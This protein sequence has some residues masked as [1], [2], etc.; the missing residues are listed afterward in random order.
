MISSQA[1]FN[2]ENRREQQALEKEIK[3]LDTE[4]AANP[5]MIKHNKIAV[6]K[7]KLNK[8]YSD[9]VVK[10]YQYTK[11]LQFEFGDKPQKLLA[12]QLR[13]LEGE[14]II[15]RIKSRNGELL[16][17]P[18]DI[19]E[20]FLQYYKNLYSVKTAENRIGIEAF[21]KKCNLKG[22][23]LENIESLNAEI[24]VKEIEESIKSLKN[25]KTP[26]PDGIGSEFYKTFYD[27]IAPRLKTLYE[28]IYTQQKLPETLNESIITLIPK[29]DKD[30]D[31][32]GSYRAIALLNTDQKI[33]TKILAQRLS[34]VINKLIHPDQTGF[35]PKR[36][37][38]YNLRRLFNIIYSK[39]GINKDLVIIS[40]DAEKAFDQVEWS[41]LFSV[42]E[43]FKL[44]EKFISWVKLL[45]ANPTA[46]ILTNQMLST[47]FNLSRGCRQ[48]CPLSPLLFALAIEPLAQSVRLHPEIYGYETR[49]TENKISLYADDVLLYIT[50]PEISILNLL[51]LITEFGSFSG[52]SINWNKSELMP[53]MVNNLHILQQYPFKIAKEKIKYLGIH[54]TKRYDSLFKSNF[55]PLLNKLNKNILY[56][57][58]LPISML[59]RINAIKM[60]FLP[61]ILYLFQLIPIYLPKFFF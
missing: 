8:I 17:N 20:R 16:V 27:L 15:H 40:L 57:K 48:G 36:Y 22:L 9:Q 41:Y 23:D 46:R 59:G 42:M 35:I 51:N 50:K 3:Q 34:T 49:E 61:Q 21:K 45:Y 32:P 18:R 47:K 11:Q 14:K 1:F 24:T 5:T 38:S 30:L 6:L 7:Y 29:I 58:T 56:W 4:N 13:K 54:V 10:L 28:H 2:K 43:T 33:L 12:R 60:I 53:I 31:D 39:R 55:P 37:S 52:Y 25:G 19:N 44:G 26:G